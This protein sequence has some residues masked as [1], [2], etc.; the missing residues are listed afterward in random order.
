M[1]RHLN[2][3]RVLLIGCCGIASACASVRGQAVAGC[4]YCG[5]PVT[6]ADPHGHAEPVTRWVLAPPA[7]HVSGPFGAE[8]A[9]SSERDD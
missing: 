4:P 9:A 6:R 5:D 8:R 7:R 3:V 1:S 2:V